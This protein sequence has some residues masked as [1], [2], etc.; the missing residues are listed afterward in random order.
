M[1]V[2]W[3][4]TVPVHVCFSSMQTG[5]HA[6][7]EA[8]DCGSVKELLLLAHL[9][10]LSAMHLRKEFLVLV[11]SKFCALPFGVFVTMGSCFCF[12]NLCTVFKNQ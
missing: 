12:M 8:S 10:Y 1:P 9:T 2:G 4:I 6:L 5:A 3:S 7:L 11:F